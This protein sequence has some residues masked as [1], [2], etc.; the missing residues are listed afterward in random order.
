MGA[1]G[2]GATVGVS[3][4]AA[5]GIP[6]DPDGVLFADGVEGDAEDGI[7]EGMRLKGEGLGANVCSETLHGAHRGV[8]RPSKN[9]TGSVVMQPD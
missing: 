9:C 4:G 8:T 1:A 5:E 3:C 2:E 7:R 6:V